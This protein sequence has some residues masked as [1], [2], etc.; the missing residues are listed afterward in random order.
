MGVELC[1]YALKCEDDSVAFWI[2]LSVDV[3]FA[4]NQ[5]HDP[6]SELF[7]YDGLLKQV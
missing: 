1:A 5:R 7:M 3:Y 2:R 6:V 4:I